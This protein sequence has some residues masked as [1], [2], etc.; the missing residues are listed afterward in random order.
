MRAKVSFSDLAYQEFISAVDLT[1]GLYKATI[2]WRVLTVG[3]HITWRVVSHP[4][5]P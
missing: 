1:V 3:L 5:F 2:T 4:G